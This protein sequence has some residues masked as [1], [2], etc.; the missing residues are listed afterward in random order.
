MKKAI[1]VKDFQGV[2]ELNKFFEQGYEIE[3]VD[4]NGIYILKRDEKQPTTLIAFNDSMVDVK[5]LSNGE[6]KVKQP[7]VR[8]EFDDIRDVPKVWIDG[9]LIEE[10]INLKVDW[11]TNT[12]IENYKEFDVNYYDLT[13][14][15]SMRRGFR[16]GTPR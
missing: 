12:Q 8:I 11:E 1:L 14:E 15:R 16:E 4:D 10:L 7:H 3:S 9:E 5:K 2:G 6:H 13:G